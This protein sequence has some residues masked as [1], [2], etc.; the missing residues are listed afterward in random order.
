MIRMTY[1]ERVAQLEATV[2]RLHRFIELVEMS[3]NG[4]DAGAKRMLR[5]ITKLLDRRSHTL[6][7]LAKRMV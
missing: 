2:D 3:S 4:W 5:G 1:K 6:W 7:V